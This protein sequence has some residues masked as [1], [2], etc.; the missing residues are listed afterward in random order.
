VGL[1]KLHAQMKTARQ[2]ILRES[3]LYQRYRSKGTQHGRR[4]ISNE[5]SRLLVILT[6][7]AFEKCI[8]TIRDNP[9]EQ[10]LGVHSYS[11][12]NHGRM[13]FPCCYASPV[14]I[15]TCAEDEVGDGRLL[16][17]RAQ[18]TECPWS[19]RSANAGI[20][21]LVRLLFPGVRWPYAAARS[22]HDQQK[23]RA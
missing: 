22:A 12:C 23:T 13:H 2:M 10:I 5:T 19:H 18:R 15:P 11:R 20:K 1:L 21:A 8:Q 9:A 3:E 16:T 4:N 14:P 6:P 17:L 7:G